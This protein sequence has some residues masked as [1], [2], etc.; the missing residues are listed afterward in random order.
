MR[1]IR[2]VY[3]DMEEEGDGWMAFQRRFDGSVDFHT[4][5]WTDYKN[6]FGTGEG[7]YWLGNDMLHKITSTGSYDLYVIAKIV[8]VENKYA[9]F[10]ESCPNSLSEFAKLIL[11]KKKINK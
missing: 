4:K 6:G 7:E 3:C 8:K 2:S 10:H 9:F 1:S 11:K 5:L